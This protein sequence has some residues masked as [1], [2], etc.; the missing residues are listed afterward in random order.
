MEVPVFVST[1]YIE[2]CKFSMFKLT[3]TLCIINVFRKIGTFPLFHHYT[4]LH[5]N[6][7]FISTYTVHFFSNR[8]NY[9]E[10]LF[11]EC[12]YL[13]L[14]LQH[15]HT[16][17]LNFIFFESTVTFLNEIDFTILFI[18]RLQKNSIKATELYTKF[19]A[20]CRL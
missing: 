16:K 12:D 3:G 5:F 15:N 14:L 11:I 7:R 8:K 1:M 6:E 13:L 17:H 4:R 2:R 10:N 20:R 9:C 19:F 18:T